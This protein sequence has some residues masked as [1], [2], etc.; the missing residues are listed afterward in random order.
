MQI[1]DTWYA[2]A[3]VAQAS[4]RKNITDHRSIIVSLRFVPI[5]LSTNWRSNK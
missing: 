4:R 2:I 5:N 3:R 1:D